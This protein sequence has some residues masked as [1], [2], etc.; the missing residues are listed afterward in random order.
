MGITTFR[1]KGLRR[2]YL[3]DDARGLRAAQIEKIRDIVT[4]LQEAAEPS[5]VALFPGWRVHRLKGDLKG[6]WSVTIT[7]NWRIIF[8]FEDGQAF[9]VDMIDYH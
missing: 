5:D 6:F 8:R 1:H 9:D 4:A 2:F 3:D 7:G